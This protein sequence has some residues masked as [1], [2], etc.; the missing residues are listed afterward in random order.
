MDF[1]QE[2]GLLAQEEL[3]KLAQT[4]ELA[5]YHDVLSGDDFRFEWTITH[6]GRSA[7]AIQIRDGS[8]RPLLHRK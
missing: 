5:S 8:A 2:A 3:C 1:D 4:H 6:A 7:R